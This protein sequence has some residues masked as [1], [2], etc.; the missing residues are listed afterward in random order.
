MP[1][2][3]LSLSLWGGGKKTY[4]LSNFK[5]GRTA[6]DRRRLKIT[7]MSPKQ[8]GLHNC[9]SQFA[10]STVINSLVILCLAYIP[11]LILLSV[12]VGSNNLEGDENGNVSTDSGCEGDNLRC[13]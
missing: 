7:A 11:S 4:F 5:K 10:S 8:V 12:N 3:G 1:L 9:R 2:A 13:D 6:S